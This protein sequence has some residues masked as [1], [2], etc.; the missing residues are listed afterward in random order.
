MPAAD[1]D[2]AL[3]GAGLQNG[4]IALGTLHRDPSCRIAMI[5]AGSSIG[6]NHTWCAHP[7]DVPA[8]AK[9]WVEPLFAH[10]WPSYQVRFPDFQRTVDSEYAAITSTRFAA[11]VE[12][13]LQ[14]S[15]QSMLLLR[16]K[17]TQLEPHA[18]TLEDGRRLTAALVVDARGPHVAEAERQAGFQKFVGLELELE[19]PHRLVAPILMDAEVEQRD[20]YRFFYTLPFGPQSLLIEDTS[21][22]CDSRL[23]YERARREVLAYAARFGTVRRVAREEDGVLPMPWSA[24]ACAPHS[25]P[26]IGGYRGGWFHPATG[27]SFPPAVRLALHIAERHPD[28]VFD[29]ALQALYRRHRRQVD[30]AQRLNRLLFG[31]F[32]PQDYWNVFARFYRMPAPVIRRFY[33]LAMTAGDRTRLLVGRPPRGFSFV[34]A[35]SLARM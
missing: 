7:Q 31:C 22:A 5:D 24:P 35:L 6:G 25:S 34:K 18:V 13:A 3:V 26:L 11:Q 28:E 30:Y 27:Y 2:M 29:I 12:A 8:A 17:V 20:G 19:Q 23:D 33:N 10:R 15:P 32:A 4:L 16:Q 21:F 9:P 14:R 1:F